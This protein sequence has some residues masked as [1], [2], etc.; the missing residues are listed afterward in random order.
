M[1]GHYFATQYGHDVQTTETGMA[2][3][4]NITT[5]ENVPE[6]FVLS[7][8][9]AELVE[10]PTLKLDAQNRCLN[11]SPVQQ[12]QINPSTFLPTP[13]KSD[14]LAQELVGYDRD[15]KEILVSCFKFGFK[16]GIL[17]NLTNRFSI[18]HKSVR[19]NTQQVYEK[20]ES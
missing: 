18:N 1:V 13:V 4:T 10:V 9:S 20:L 17:G 2:P 6:T 15:L 12:S 14:F 3:V 16:V 8:T 11:L 19:E 5:R 7:N